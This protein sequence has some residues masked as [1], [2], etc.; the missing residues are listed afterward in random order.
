MAAAVLL[1]TCR[2]VLLHHGRRARA[3]PDD[4]GGGSG[5][6]VMMLEGLALQ[7]KQT[8][9]RA[10]RRGVGGSGGG[11]PSSSSS[12][13]SSQGPPG[14]VVSVAIALALAVDEVSYLSHST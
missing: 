11:D 14:G 8:C 1:G 5:G 4:G 7:Y 12:S 9:L 10:L 2:Y 13:S 3:P 6:P